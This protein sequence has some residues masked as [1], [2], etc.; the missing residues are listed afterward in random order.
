MLVWLC[1]IVKMQKAILKCSV[2]VTNK[3]TAE[4]YVYFISLT[5]AR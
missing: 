2:N 3:I 1:G 4:N 5:K